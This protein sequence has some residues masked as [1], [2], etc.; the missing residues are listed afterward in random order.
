[1][2]MDLSSLKEGI[3]ALK[4]GLSLWKQGKDLIPDSDKKQEAEK[5]FTEA[6]SKL[7]LGEEKI[8]VELGYEICRVHWPP[9]IMLTIAGNRNIWKC[10]K[11]GEE[12]DKS[13]IIESGPS[14]PPSITMDTEF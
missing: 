10:P 9:E 2:D 3:D 7:K 1:M 4:I 12:L 6:E 14:P 11:C 8:A 13:P 5:A